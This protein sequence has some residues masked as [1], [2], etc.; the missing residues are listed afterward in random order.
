MTSYNLAPGKFILFGDSITE[1][2]WQSLPDSTRTFSL[3][4]AFGNHY[5]RKLD[6]VNRGYSGYTSDQGAIIF[7]KVVKNEPDI[8]LATVFYGTNDS[9]YGKDA[10]LSVPLERFRSNIEAIIKLSAVHNVKLILI[11]PTFHDQNILDRLFPEKSKLDKHKDISHTS[12]YVNTLLELG[13]QY[14]LPVIN[15]YEIFQKYEGDWSKD[16]L[17]DGLHFNGSGYKILHDQII[18]VISE[19]YPEL[20]A[21]NLPTVLPDFSDLPSI[22]NFKRCVN[23]S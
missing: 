19:W 4:A 18:K 9:T 8:K 3:M 10:V 7:S 14:Q 5:V 11:A 2:S 17:I 22:E 12:K 6:I 15:L 20:S 16:L 21:D 1:F 13:E 23:G